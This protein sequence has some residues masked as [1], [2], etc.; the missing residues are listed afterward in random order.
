MEDVADKERAGTMPYQS[1]RASQIEEA[2]L[3]I[4]ILAH[5]RLQTRL[6]AHTVP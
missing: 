4:A 1:G 2:Q 5:D 3:G 6:Q